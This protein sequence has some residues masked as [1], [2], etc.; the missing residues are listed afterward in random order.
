MGRDRLA[1]GITFVWGIA[2]L[3][4][5]FTKDTTVV[6]IVTPV[7]LVVAGFFFGRG[8]NGNGNGHK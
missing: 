5:L 4:S 7:M 6:A 3:V 8:R 1:F 2:T